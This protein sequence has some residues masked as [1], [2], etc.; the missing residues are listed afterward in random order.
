MT[1]TLLIGMEEHQ[2]CL[3]DHLERIHIFS[4]LRQSSNE[5]TES[6]RRNRSWVFLGEAA[7]S[8]NSGTA[9]FQEG[10]AR[11]S[12]AESADGVGSR[13]LG[14]RL[15]LENAHHLGIG[16]SCSGSHGGYRVS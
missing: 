11:E 14:R 3:Q 1:Y 4:I 15:G 13:L 2:Q 16:S 9:V 12:A 6:T 5:P 7:E 8:K 10:G